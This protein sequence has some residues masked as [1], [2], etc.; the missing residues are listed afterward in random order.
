MS[1][2]D[3]V[4]ATVR[5]DEQ[6]HRYELVVSDQVVCEADYDDAG[7]VR[8]FTHTLTA[9]AARGR[10]YAARLVEHALDDTRSAGLTV[11]PAC[12]FV[13]EFIAAHPAYEDLLA[14]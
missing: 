13:A 7:G 5:H 10:G 6:R 8:S 1:E 14:S 3:Q 4:Q 9:P 11:I 12:W 2:P